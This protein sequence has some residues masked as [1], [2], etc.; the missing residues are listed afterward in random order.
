[1]K[2]FEFFKWLLSFF[3][4]SKDRSKTSPTNSITEKI[5]PVVFACFSDQDK[6]DVINILRP[7]IKDFNS[8]SIYL[9]ICQVFVENKI[10]KTFASLSEDRKTLTIT[11]TQS[12]VFNEKISEFINTTVVKQFQ[13]ELNEKMTDKYQVT[14]KNGSILIQKLQE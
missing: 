4:G 7:L 1:M 5:V 8:N 2:F 14:A 3:Y 10:L 6:N 12:S 11:L 13:N 9:S